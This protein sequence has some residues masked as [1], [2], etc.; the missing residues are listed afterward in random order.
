MYK[1]SR[2]INAGTNEIYRYGHKA[3]EKAAA[4]LEPNEAGFYSIPTDAGAWWTLGTSEGRY[5]EFMRYEDTFFSVNSRGNAWAKVGT[6]KAEAFVDMINDMIKKM[7]A[8]DEERL[9]ALQ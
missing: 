2:Y 8:L 9:S 7:E 4:C 5:G 1:G 3:R 6:P